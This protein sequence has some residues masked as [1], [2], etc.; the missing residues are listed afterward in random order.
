MEKYIVD[1]ILAAIFIII[2]ARYFYKG[3]ADTILRFAAY[4]VSAVLS[5][6]MST[7]ITEWII[8]NTK[9]FSGTEKY[10]TKLIVVIVSFLVF[11]YIA[12][13]IVDLIGKVLKVP[14]LKQANKL[15]GGLLGAVSAGFIIVIL[16]I[17]LQI[18]THVLYNSK[19]SDLVENSVIVQTV[20]SD[21]KISN[22]IKAFT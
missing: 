22:N 15:L 7:P 20:L 17:A 8:G 18:S 13:L 9:L 19:Y 6:V 21:E 4:V 1:I 11:Y 10:I 16:C 14:V 3:F 2:T 5:V 12:N